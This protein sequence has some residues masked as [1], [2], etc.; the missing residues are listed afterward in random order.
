MGGFRIVW[1]RMER[2]LI[3]IKV[4]YSFVGFGRMFIVFF[5]CREGVFRDIE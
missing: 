4:I 2:G 5:V 3:G 1:D